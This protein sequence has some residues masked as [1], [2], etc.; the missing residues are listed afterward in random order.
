MLNFGQVIPVQLVFIVHS[1]IVYFI[2]LSK[3]S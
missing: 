3:V 2:I 1:Q